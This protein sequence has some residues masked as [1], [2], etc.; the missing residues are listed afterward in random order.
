MGCRQGGDG[1][2]DIGTIA[3]KGQVP[4]LVRQRAAARAGEE[5]LFGQCRLMSR[6]GVGSLAGRLGSML[7]WELGPAHWC[8]DVS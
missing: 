5:E 3:D 4:S 7:E 8:W 6:T 2:L 1:L